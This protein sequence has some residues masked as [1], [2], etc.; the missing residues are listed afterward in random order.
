MGFGIFAAWLAGRPV[1]HNK[2]AGG[3]LT[4]M[5]GFANVSMLER[6]INIMLTDDIL[7]KL[8]RS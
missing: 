5:G 6:K 3:V 4:L 8:I 1:F 7:K 2:G